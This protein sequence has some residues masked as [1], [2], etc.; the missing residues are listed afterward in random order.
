VHRPLVGPFFGI[1]HETTMACTV[2]I[3]EV[4]ATLLI[5]LGTWGTLGTR[6]GEWLDRAEARLT[7]IL[8]KPSKTY[9]ASTTRR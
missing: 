3:V 6:A 5:V 7:R 9:F 4:I 1:T 2:L 8:T